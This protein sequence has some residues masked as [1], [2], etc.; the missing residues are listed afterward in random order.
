MTHYFLE[1]QSEDV[2]K[3]ASEGKLTGPEFVG[4]GC[5]YRV[6]SD[7]YGYYVAEILE[8]G[9][10]VALIGADDEYVTSWPDGNMVCTM[11][12]DKLVKNAVVGPAGPNS[13]FD[14]IMRYGKSWYR[15]RVID[16]KITRQRGNHAGL[17]WNGA[18]SYRDPSL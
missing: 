1:I 3:R 17:S 9:R 4:Q 16:G 14:Y 5:T 7:A 15:C 18:F 2:R 11:P 12:T 10:L 13:G 8:P 6:G